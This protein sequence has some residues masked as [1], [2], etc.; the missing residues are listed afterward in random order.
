MIILEKNMYINRVENYKYPTFGALIFKSGASEYLKTLGKNALE[1]LDVVR[2]NLEST[3]F[4]NLEMRETP[5]IQNIK[6]NERIYPPFNLSKAGK[7]LILRS[8]CGGQI[9]SKKLKYK[10]TNE[11]ERIYKDITQSETQILR[12]GKIVK[13][14]EEY[15]AKSQIRDIL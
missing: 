11:V 5:V 13:Y 8:R 2:K 7:S 10:N 14:L 9:D 4:Y 3:Q 6:S 12:T 15:E 1:D